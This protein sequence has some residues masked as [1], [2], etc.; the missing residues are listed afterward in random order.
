MKRIAVVVVV[1][2]TLAGC[3]SSSNVDSKSAGEP[4]QSS[5]APLPGK[6]YFQM[7]AANDVDSLE[8][9]RS[10][11]APGSP[12]RA[13]ASHRYFAVLSDAD[14][15]GGTAKMETTAWGYSTCEGADCIQFAD[16]KVEQG[17]VRTFDVSGEDISNVVSEG[18][19]KT[20]TLGNLGS[21]KIVSSYLSPLSGNLFVTVKFASPPRK[22]ITTS[23]VA[24]YRGPD[25]RQVDNT[26]Q[27]GPT[28][29]QPDSVAYNVFVF[30]STKF[31]GRILVKV[32][33]DDID[34]NDGA[35]SK[36]LE[37]IG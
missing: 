19:G 20:V 34:S 16:I 21:A 1:A 23:Y 7:L 37:T 28:T 35:V 30:K 9:A 2:L 4:A 29:L 11:A 8:K 3:G 18:T 14:W 32:A 12:A 10:L 13:Y 5:A 36:S 6:Q 27:V 17:K 15:A 26:D 33:N 24:T 22:T 25:K 31:G